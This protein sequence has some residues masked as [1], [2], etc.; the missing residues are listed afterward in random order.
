MADNLV[1][2]TASKANVQPSKAK[3]RRKIAGM[4]ALILA[5]QRV[6]AGALGGYEARAR[7]GAENIIRS[8]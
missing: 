3:S 7:S 2:T 8:L 4:V 5:L 1:A 6:I